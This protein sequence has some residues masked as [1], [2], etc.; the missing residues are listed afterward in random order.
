MTM[1]LKSA[2]AYR[3]GKY[4]YSWALMSVNDPYFSRLFV[5]VSP[6]QVPSL[7][8]LKFSF[9]FLLAYWP[10]GE[11]PHLD[12]LAERRVPSPRAAS[13][14]TNFTISW[15]ERTANPPSSKIEKPVPHCTL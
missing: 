4:G 15:L 6:F 3:V 7:T 1:P 2:R 13:P 10:S 14:L 5:Y 8:P 12:L 11:S 9:L